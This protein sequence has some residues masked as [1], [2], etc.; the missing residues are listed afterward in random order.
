MVTF[1]M[2]K[3]SGTA[4]KTGG[5][6]GLPK[7]NKS[8]KTNVDGGIGS[9]HK[10]TTTPGKAAVGTFSQQVARVAANAAANGQTR[11]SGV[12]ANSG[13]IQRSGGGDGGNAPG[14]HGSVPNAN[15]FNA[16]KAAN[17]RVTASGKTPHPP[18]IDE[19]PTVTNGK[20]KNL[21]MSGAAKPNDNVGYSG[22]SNGKKAYGQTGSGIGKKKKFGAV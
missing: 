22:S 3:K 4:G 9:R 15:Q 5:I 20:N 12:K 16:F 17:V 7:S 2:V 21:T 6:S 14:K 1:T 13:A 8:A 18:P 19:A 11:N 10:G